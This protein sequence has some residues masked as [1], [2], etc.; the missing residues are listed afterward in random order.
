MQT[1]TDFFAARR[2]EFPSLAQTVRELPAVFFD[3]PGGSQAPARVGD[4]MGAYLRRDNANTGGAFLT[5]QRTDAL[6][7]GTR[8]AMANFLGAA[9]GEEIVFG[10]NMTSLTFALSRALART[11]DAG[12]EVVLTSLD[13]DANFT[14]WVIAAHDRGATLRTWE[15]RPEEGCRLRLDDLGPL[16]NPR[17]RLVALT[18]ASNAVGTIPEVAGA[19]RLV[20]EHAPAAR[21]FVDAVH[22]APHGPLDVCALDCDFLACSAYKFFGPHLGILYGK[23]EVLDGLVADKVR[24][25]SSRPP[26]KW[27]TGTQS[28]ESIAGLRACLQYLAE[29]GGAASGGGTPPEREFFERAMREIQRHE[30]DLTRTFLGLFQA[31]ALPGWRLHGITDVAACGERTPTFALTCG[32]RSPREVAERLAERGFFVWDGN[33]YAVNVVER[34]GLGERGGLLRIGFLHYNTPDEVTRLVAALTEIARG[35]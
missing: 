25:S 33:I 9:R 34:L 21:V 10:Q 8:Q 14:P 11:W 30:A 32:A 2:A 19:I 6:V 3:G 4:A 23:Y 29:T 22:F 20:R 18:H 26:G 15:F 31:A 16:L 7:A 5:S 17:T 28:F 12:D 24:P 27:E 35:G 13:H 1:R